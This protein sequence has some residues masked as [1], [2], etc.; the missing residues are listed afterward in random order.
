[1]LP[2]RSNGSHSAKPVLLFLDPRPSSWSNTGIKHYLSDTKSA[3]GIAYDLKSC[4]WR[5]FYHSIGLDI[6]SKGRE[7]MHG[8]VGE[9]EGGRYL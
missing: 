8:M 5:L 7:T 4:N 9:R 6:S 1:M 3:F 2:T